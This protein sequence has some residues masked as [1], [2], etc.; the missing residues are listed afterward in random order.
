VGV[1]ALVVAALAY[2]IFLRNDEPTVKPAPQNRSLVEPP[3]ISPPAPIQ[4]P[5]VAPQPETTPPIAAAAKTNPPAVEAPAPSKPPLDVEMRVSE[6]SWVQVFT[7]GATTATD[8]GEFPPGTTRRYSAQKSIEL[9]IG[10]AGGL[11]LK[12]NDREISS[13]GKSGEVR[14]LTITPENA[15]R[16][17]TPGN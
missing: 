8:M 16:I 11:S 4:N 3:A 7:D 15:S 9:R 12:V 5:P 1:A 10:N 6:T 13:L 2:V 14:Y 17:G